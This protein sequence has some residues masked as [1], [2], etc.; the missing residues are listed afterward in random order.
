MRSSFDLYRYSIRALR[1]VLPM[2][3]VA[4][5]LIL[6][7]NIVPASKIAPLSYG[8]AT[9]NIKAGRMT[10]AR[11]LG[12]DEAQQPFR[13]QAKSAQQHR[14]TGDVTLNTL[15]ASLTLN[16][17]ERASLEAR[18]AYYD[19]KARTIY[20]LG[21]VQVADGR[22]YALDIHDLT[23]DV[24][25]QQAMTTGKVRADTPQGSINAEGLRIL[26][27]GKRL[28]FTGSS[29]MHVTNATS[30]APALPKTPILRLQ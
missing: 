17:G 30:Q 3:T 14:T 27:A 29:S 21:S 20:L 25:G 4:L 12:V 11:F 24:D 10:N 23:V 6:Y 7:G 19:H 16:T 5:L 22:G 13:L 9:A 26:E 18:Q 15:S 28:V 1:Y 8:Q 2:T